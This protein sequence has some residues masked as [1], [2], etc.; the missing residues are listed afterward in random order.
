MDVQQWAVIGCDD[1]G[2]TVE[3]TGPD[4]EVLA[5]AVA[6]WAQMEEDKWPQLG[7]LYM[8]ISPDEVPLAREE[9]AD[10]A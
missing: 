10:S 2:V 7:L 8:L 3:K 4:P 6:S 9:E 5:D 1:L